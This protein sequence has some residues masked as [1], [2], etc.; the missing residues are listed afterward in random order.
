MSTR[1][2]VAGLIVSAITFVAAIVR[3]LP[4][5]DL[6]TS[7][8]LVLQALVY[9][10]SAFVAVWL[11]EAIYHILRRVVCAFLPAGPQP[12]DRP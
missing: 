1:W 5:N 7:L 3:P 8:P 12:R 10:V 6:L 2:R 11:Y 4:G 9:A